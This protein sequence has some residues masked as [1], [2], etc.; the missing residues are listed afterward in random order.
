MRA[1]PA[2]GCARRRP[3]RVVAGFSVTAGDEG[4][5][6]VPLATVH[7]PRPLATVHFPVAGPGRVPGA[8][9]PLP[10]GSLTRGAGRVRR[11]R[12]RGRRRPGRGSSHPLL[13][14]GSGAGHSTVGGSRCMIRVLPGGFIVRRGGH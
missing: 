9:G 11:G 10:A 2:S 5:G 6:L 12:V 1:G 7:F 13:S 4:P 8:V 3:R 14:V